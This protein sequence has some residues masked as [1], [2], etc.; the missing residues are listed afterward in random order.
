MSFAASITLKDRSA[1]NA[2]FNRIKSLAGKVYYLLSTATLALPYGFTIGQQMASKPTAASRH[3]FQ[4]VVP[5]NT[6]KGDLAQVTIN[7][8]C[9]HLA[10]AARTD[11]DNGL[12][13]VKEFI[14]Q[15]ALIDA[16]LRGEE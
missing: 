7:L 10:D 6:M 8:T 2:V 12:A 14:S 4:V 3:L 5:Y 15:T 9:S 13:N 11:I 16:W 1:A